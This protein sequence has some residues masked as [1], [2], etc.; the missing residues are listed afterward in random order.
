MKTTA[1]KDGGSLRISSLMN[2]QSPKTFSKPSVTLPA[3]ASTNLATTKRESLKRNS[4]GLEI[5]SE[6]TTSPKS[7][8]NLFPFPACTLSMDITWALEFLISAT[9]F[10]SANS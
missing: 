7:E 9:R 3:K 10:L 6:R 1:I 8:N 5:Y 4:S 2:Y